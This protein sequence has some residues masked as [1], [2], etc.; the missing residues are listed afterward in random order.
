LTHIYVFNLVQGL[1]CLC[2][3][4]L[5]GW[6]ER[7]TAIFLLGASVATILLPFD[8]SRSFRTVETLELLIDVSLMAGLISVALLANRFWPLWLTALH[9]LAIGIH[10]V[11]G[12]DTAL[13]PW[14]Y[15]A[16]GGKIAYPMIALLAIG[17]LRHRLR[18]ARYGRDPD[19]TLPWRG[20]GV[21]R[22][23]VT[24]DRV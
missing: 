8:P 9:L 6:P 22:G 2:A 10:G 18:L 1:I 11:K 7:W 15:A 14:M 23:E 16:A 20:Y 4:W 12:F 13:V 24:H 17:V 3:L 21:G 19:W 5:G